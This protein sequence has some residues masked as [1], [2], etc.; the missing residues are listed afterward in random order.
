[1]P[2]YKVFDTEAG[3]MYVIAESMALACECWMARQAQEK[4][5]PLD[6]AEEPEHI[7]KLADDD[8]ILFSLPMDKLTTIVLRRPT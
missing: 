3:D 2:L 4:E 6:D 5:I 7:A 8:Q 1:M